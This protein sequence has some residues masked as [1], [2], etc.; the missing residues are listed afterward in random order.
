MR[1]TS[2]RSVVMDGSAF[3]MERWV[4]GAVNVGKTC[5]SN[6]KTFCV[7]VFCTGMCVCTLCC[8]ADMF[9]K[10]STEPQNRA[11]QAVRGGRAIE[12]AIKVCVGCSF[13][14]CL[15]RTRYCLWSPPHDA[16]LRIYYVRLIGSATQ[17]NVTGA[18]S[19][20]SSVAQLACCGQLYSLRTPR[21]SPELTSSRVVRFS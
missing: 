13:S 8:S 3:R 21:P 11:R 1:R 9:D 16:L 18:P 2:S 20:S 7:Y 4:L 19:K 15:S 5:E 17:G 10:N 6:D 14:S 12:E